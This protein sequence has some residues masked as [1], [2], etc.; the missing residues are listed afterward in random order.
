MLAAELNIDR[1]AMDVETESESIQIHLWNQLLLHV[2]NDHGLIPLLALPAGSACGAAG[3]G[4][5]QSSMRGKESSG[6]EGEVTSAYGAMP[7]Y[8]C[9]LLTP[10]VIAGCDRGR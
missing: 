10:L 7:L 2:L 4:G 8:M 5:S 3:G 6:A 9:R 1:S